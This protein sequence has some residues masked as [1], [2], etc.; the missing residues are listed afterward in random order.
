[1]RKTMKFKNTKTG[2]VV[3]VP[4]KL[5]GPKWVPVEKPEPAKNQAKKKNSK[6]G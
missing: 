4:S 1:M 3:D 2:A 5:N 6:K